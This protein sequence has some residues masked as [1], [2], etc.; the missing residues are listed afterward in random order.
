MTEIDGDLEY[1]RNFINKFRTQFP[2]T[3]LD[4]SQ[5]VAWG[6]YVCKDLERNAESA[7]IQTWV[8]GGWTRDDAAWMVGT[9]ENFFCPSLRGGD[10]LIPGA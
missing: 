3:T 4:S 8:N 2:S 10:V 7:V 5:I 6:H 1:N 9:S